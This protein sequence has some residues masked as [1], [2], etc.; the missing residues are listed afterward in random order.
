MR[1]K[2]TPADFRLGGMETYEGPHGHCS[3]VMDSPGAGVYAVRASGR[4]L[5]LSTRALSKARAAARKCV[6]RHSR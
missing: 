4:G 3:I 1:R 2:L 6:T 5:V